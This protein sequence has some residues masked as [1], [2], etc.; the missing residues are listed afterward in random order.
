[1]IKN[2][3]QTIFNWI[4][5]IFFNWT[6]YNIT[7]LRQM[8]NNS[9]PQTNNSNQNYSEELLSIPTKICDGIFMADE[10]IAQVFYI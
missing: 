7:I 5:S 6:A 9:D 2:K 8:K 4:I 3:A 1:M 10:L